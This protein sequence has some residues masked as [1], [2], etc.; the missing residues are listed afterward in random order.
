MIACA[1]E[2]LI[3]LLYFGF[4]KKERES[5]EASSMVDKLLTI[6]MLSPTTIESVC[7]AISAN[8]YSLFSDT[9]RIEY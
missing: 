2:A 3:N 4:D 8:V 1:L 6:A 9:T 7:F 5:D